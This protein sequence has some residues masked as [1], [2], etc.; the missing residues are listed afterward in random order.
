MKN[1]VTKLNWVYSNKFF[2]N[3]WY[4]RPKFNNWLLYRKHNSLRGKRWECIKIA[5]TS[6]YKK[7][8]F[9]WCIFPS[10]VLLSLISPTFS[11]I[12]SLDPCIDPAFTVKVVGHQWYWTY[13]L[14][15]IIEL[16]DVDVFDAF[17]DKINLIE[18]KTGL[19]TTKIS[20]EMIRY[21]DLDLGK[22]SFNFSIDSVMIAENDL[23]FGSHRL[24]EVD[25]RLVLPIGVPIRFLITATD[26]LHS[27]ALPT[28]GFKV[29]AVPG[30]LNQ[31]I[32]EIKKPGVFYGQC[33]ELCGQMHGFMPIVIQAVTLD[34]FEAWLIT[35]SS[36]L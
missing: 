19:D 14:D 27:W 35:K 1:F 24:L 31:F 34:Q 16:K 25:N 18:S 9:Y 30:R 26:V 28:L 2:F 3:I 22:I 4:S 21:F 32:V 15:G 36:N 20:K 29:D 5:D 8:E 33:S 12:F 6:E 7:L 17:S 10:A 11:L 13:Q 23:S